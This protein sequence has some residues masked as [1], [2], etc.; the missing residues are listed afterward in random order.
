LT[1]D[2]EGWRIDNGLTSLRSK[3]YAALPAGWTI[4]GPSRLDDGSWTVGAHLV[5]RTGGPNEVILIEANNADLVQAFRDLEAK[6]REM[7]L[8]RGQSN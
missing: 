5:Q 7:D 8:P 2:D 4:N 6:I 3:I 1:D